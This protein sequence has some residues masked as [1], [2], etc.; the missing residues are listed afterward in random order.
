ME[1]RNTR[2]DRY[3]LGLANKPRPRIC[4]LGTASGD[5]RDYIRRFHLAMNRLPC[6]PSDL[7]LYRRDA[8]NLRKFILSQDVIFVGGGNTANLLAVWRLHGLDRILREA[9]RRGVVLSGVSA[10]MICWFESCP[11]APART[12]TAT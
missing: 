6:R 10:G 2:L 11:A 8:R 12:M 9:W 7:T 5:S 1:P 4:F 3:I